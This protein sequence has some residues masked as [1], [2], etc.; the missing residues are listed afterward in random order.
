MSFGTSRNDGYLYHHTIKPKQNWGIIWIIQIL[1]IISVL[2][3]VSKLKLESEIPFEDFLS[4]LPPDLVENIGKPVTV[5]NDE[6][7]EEV[8]TEKANDSVKV[9]NIESKTQSA[10]VSL[11]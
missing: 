7:K 4:Q 11:I 9:E 8:E 3:E 6:E 10:D 5:E 1:L 2:D